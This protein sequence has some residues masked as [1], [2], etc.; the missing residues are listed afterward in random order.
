MRSPDDITNAGFG[1]QVSREQ[2]KGR[3]ECRQ[4]ISKCIFEK[5]DMKLGMDGTGSEKSNG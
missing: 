2:V 3:I 4:R 5:Y 1:R